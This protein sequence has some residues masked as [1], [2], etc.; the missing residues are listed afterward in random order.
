MFP[1][2]HI[3]MQG[4]AVSERVLAPV[5][6]EPLVPGDGE[7]LA[8]GDGEPL[9]PGDGEAAQSHNLHISRAV[10]QMF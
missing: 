10:Q 7:P 2:T 4:R 6:G 3:I 5:L 9:A 8:P 1:A